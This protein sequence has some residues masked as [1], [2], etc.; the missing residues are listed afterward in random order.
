[1]NTNV[2]ASNDLRSVVSQEEWDI[3]VDLAAAYRLV[4]LFGW[5]DLVFTHISARIPGPEHHFLINPYG[6]MFEEI[7]A[8]S[9]VKVDLEGRQVIESP[10]QTNP[11]GFT[12]HSCI[13]AAREDAQ[14]ILHVHSLHGSA[15]A[16]QRDG[17]LPISQKSIFVLASL[18]YHAYE[19]VALNAD[20]QPRLVKDLGVNHFLL[21]RN[22]GL[23]TVGKTPADAFLRM[24]Q[25]ETAC[26]L[27][28]RA[29]SGGG[30]LVMIDQAILATA[31]S[32]SRQVTRG[33]GASLIWPGLLRRLN[34]VNPGYAD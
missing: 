8:S 3:R 29:Q 26:S 1:M 12:I 34:R 13:H 15:V 25:F 32:A 20:E 27:Q 4:A 24:Y 6:M 2:I 33:L 22:H 21:L 16:A 5:D 17:V 18:G 30:E 7:T 19:G 11:A 9:L 31:S 10:Y 28:I 14:C 23:L